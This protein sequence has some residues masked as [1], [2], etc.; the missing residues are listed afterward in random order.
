M[1]ITKKEIE[2]ILGFKIKSYKILKK[3]FRGKKVSSMT[4]V[5]Q[6][7]KEPEQ[8]TITVKSNT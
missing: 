6:L 5:V 1:E 3:A 7:P 2:K 8:I 4:V